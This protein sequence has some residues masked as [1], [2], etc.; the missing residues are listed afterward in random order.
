MVNLFITWDESQQTILSMIRLYALCLAALD[1]VV[2][3]DEWWERR[4]EYYNLN[5]RDGFYCLHGHD[6][7]ER[8]LPPTLTLL[9]LPC[10]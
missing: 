4:N 1:R 5:A 2:E 6:S 10:G 9:V 3:I 8:W 7:P